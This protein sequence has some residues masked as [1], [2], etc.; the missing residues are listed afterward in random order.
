MSVY[1]EG[2][3]YIDGGTVTNV[4]VQNV[5]ITASSINMNYQSIT[6]VKDPFGLQDA[7]TK[8]YVDNK[9]YGNV[10]G[11]FSQG[12]II[13]GGTS[14]N[15]LVGYPNFNYNYNNGLLSLLNTTNST[16]LTD[17][18]T[19]IT[20]GGLTIAKDLYVGGQIINN[21]QKIQ[22]LGDISERFTFLNNNQVSKLDITGFVFSNVVK[23]FQS[24]TCVQI[25]TNPS[26]IEVLL[27]IKGLRRASS[28]WIINIVE[29]GD[30]I[31]NIIKFSITS[32]G[33]VQYTSSNVPNWVST[34]INFRAVT[35]SV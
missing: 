8:N 12:Q 31:R 35:T 26:N 28:G 14:P 18:G 22:S 32:N 17:G 25:L 30:S 7:A 6:N 15:T 3:A 16:S 27:E 24:I 23:S 21:G 34:K 20:N 33:Q 29:L 1:F 4:D 2:N 5:A 19:F 11:N 10:N 13:I 9:T